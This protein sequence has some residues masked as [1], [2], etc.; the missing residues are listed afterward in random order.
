MNKEV[1]VTGMMMRTAVGSNLLISET[2]ADAASYKND[3]N[4]VRACTLEPSSTID[5]INY[6]W[7]STSN[8]DAAGNA[9]AE[10]YTAYSEATDLAHSAA[11]K[12]AY[13]TAFNTNYAFTSP[14]ATYTGVAYG[15]VDY[16][17]YLKAVNTEQTAQ[18][19]NLTKLN[20]LYN[21]AAPTAG[22][23]DYAVVDKAWRTALIVQDI[24]TDFA[25]GSTFTNNI[26]APIAANTVSMFTIDG[27]AN[28]T[29][30]DYAVGK[31]GDSDPTV[32][33]LS[34]GASKTAYN[35]A[36]TLDSI[37]AGAEK[38]YK[39]TVRVWLEGEDTTCT[40]QTYATLKN[41]YT[42]D[43]KFEYG[44]TPVTN[45]SNTAVQNATATLASGTATAAIAG[46]ATGGAH[47][48][49]TAAHYQWYKVDN[50][51]EYT[52]VGTDAATYTVPAG[53]TVF[54]VIE[55]STGL[56]YWTNTVTNSST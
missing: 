3:L 39:V 7:T 36:G 11:G 2:N 44:G 5:G 38:H 24:T 23:G 18:N 20:L 29:S 31:A 48:D 35:V 42:L 47:E 21:G 37:A 45:I 16:T 19:L 51:F 4:Q 28:H 13:D 27:A 17:F 1:S 30:T 52:A 26:A 50:A 9:I 32:M 46:T 34:Y 56:K 12:T 43:L 40:N 54:C 22:S 33:D 53:D 8:V 6:Y 49:E 10:D 14:T 41:N 15:Y 55:T 25:Y